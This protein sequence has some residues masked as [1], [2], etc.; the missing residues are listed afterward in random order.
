MSELTGDVDNASEESDGDDHPSHIPESVEMT[1]ES[2]K[3]FMKQ[4]R[5][6]DMVHGKF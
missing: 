5:F 3:A 6:C 4:V 1:T 2:V